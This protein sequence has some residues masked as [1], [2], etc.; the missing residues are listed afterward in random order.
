MSSFGRVFRVTTFGES[1]GGGVGCV[2]EGVPPC[3]DLDA[4]VHVQ[5]QLRRRRPGQSAVSTDRSEEDTATV[6]AGTENGKTLGTPVIVLVRNADH[7]P[8]DYAEMSQ[9]RNPKQKQ[10]IYQ[11][12]YSFSFC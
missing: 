2:V 12:T 7:R 9:E 3:M 6:L 4:A 5:P 8:A 10:P 11:W 1:H